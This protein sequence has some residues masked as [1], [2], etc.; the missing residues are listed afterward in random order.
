MTYRAKRGENYWLQAQ[1]K[2]PLCYLFCTM[3]KKS[4]FSSWPFWSQKVMCSVTGGQMFCKTGVKTSVRL[5]RRKSWSG[6]AESAAV[7]HASESPPPP[8]RNYKKIDLPQT[9]EWSSW[10]DLCPGPRWPLHCPCHWTGEFDHWV[11]RTD[12]WPLHSGFLAPRHIWQK[13]MNFRILE[14]LLNMNVIC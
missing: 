12:W 14:T 7:L 11:W 6:A 10:L 8:W 2:N 4:H 9:L 3:K 13:I 1:K 5:Q